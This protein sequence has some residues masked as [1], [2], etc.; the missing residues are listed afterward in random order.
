M[1]QG[2]PSAERGGDIHRVAYIDSVWRVSAS[3]S[4]RFA[5]KGSVGNS[6]PAEA[7]PCSHGL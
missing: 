2:T 7:G 5:E 1:P 4:N 3:R 6:R